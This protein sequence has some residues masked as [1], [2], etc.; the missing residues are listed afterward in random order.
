MTAVDFRSGGLQG[1]GPHSPGDPHR[2]HW[3]DE[4]WPAVGAQSWQD[5]TWDDEDTPAAPLSLAQRLSRLTHYF[6]ALISVGLIVV[7]AVWGV[8]LVVRD[9]SGVPVI[10]AIQGDARTAPDDPGGEL[11]SRTGLAVNAVAGG[12]KAGVADKVAIAPPAT[13]LQPQDVPMGEL[14]AR[15]RTPSRAVELAPDDPARRVVALPDGEAA[16]AA[17]AAAGA[18]AGGV[19][20]A[21]ISDAPAAEAPVN[22]ALTDLAGQETRDNA[23]AQ[24][25]AEANASA[26]ALATPAVAQSTRPAPRPRRVAMAPAA[27][28]PARAVAPDAEQPDAAPDASPDRPAPTPAAPAAQARPAAGAAMAQIGAFDSDRLARGEWGRVSGKFGALFAGKS[29]IVQ[30]H[31]ANGRTFWRLR[32][33]GFASKDEARRFCAALIAEGV[34][35]IPA[36]AK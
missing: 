30:E 34:D 16:Q 24:A 29:M 12:G 14:G 1:P 3:Q 26:A 22:E 32:A 10:R 17:A 33:G 19:A 8:K 5:G 11:T 13:G 36:T 15:A 27:E 4:D 23:I 35:C 21:V 18:G 9:V 7:L 28:A 2:G 31:K 20:D 6:G 25:L